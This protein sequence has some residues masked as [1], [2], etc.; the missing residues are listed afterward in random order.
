MHA[1]TAGAQSADL[2]AIWPKEAEMPNERIRSLLK[3]TWVESLGKGFSIFQ[4]EK[5]MC[6]LI[7]VREMRL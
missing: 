6:F 3:G 2:L 5:S 4:Y 7:L 1:K